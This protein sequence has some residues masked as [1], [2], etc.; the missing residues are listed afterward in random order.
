MAE[1]LGSP[2]TLVT[3]PNSLATDSTFL[4]R[5]LYS[6]ELSYKIQQLAIHNEDPGYHGSCEEKTMVSKQ[7]CDIFLSFAQEDREF[8]EEVKARLQTKKKLKV[9]VPSEGMGGLL[10]EM[11]EKALML[12]HRLEAH[13][14]NLQRERRAN[15]TA[16]Q[17]P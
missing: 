15:P 1:E 12:A 4:S 6:H 13:S 9:F 10:K 11:Q 5:G 17:R 7:R 2:D 3:P 16:D 14:R 8:A